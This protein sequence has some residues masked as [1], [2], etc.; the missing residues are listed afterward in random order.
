MSKATVKMCVTTTGFGSQVRFARQRQDD[1]SPI[2]PQHNFDQRNPPPSNF[3]TMGS[4]PPPQFDYDLKTLFSEDAQSGRM[5]HRPS[6]TWQAPLLSIAPN[7]APTYAYT[8]SDA[9][10]P[11]TLS[12]LST[13]AANPQ[14]TQMAP[15][16]QPFDS[17]LLPT[18]FPLSDD[19]NNGPTAYDNYDFDFLMNNDTTN[20]AAVFSGDVG[21]NLGFDGQHDW[22]EGGG[23][24]PDLFGGFFFGPQAGGEGGMDSG[25]GFTGGGFD[26]GI[27]NGP[28]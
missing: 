17:S 3:S 4:R 12:T 6:Q 25:G 8:S 2:L 20:T 26:D 21:A 19:I 13:T 7:Q 23:Q 22:A 24:L 14:Q 15:P 5:F 28:G 9:S 27:W 18:S 16:N 10:T 1:D 11:S